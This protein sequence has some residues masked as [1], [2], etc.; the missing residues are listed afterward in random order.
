MSTRSQA[1]V[2]IFKPV[3]SLYTQVLNVI[4]KK[5]RDQYHFNILK[6]YNFLDVV[7]FLFNYPSS[8]SARQAS[9]RGDWLPQFRKTTSVVS[10]KVVGKSISIPPNNRYSGSFAVLPEAFSKVC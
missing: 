6:K 4:N 1:G 3:D 10:D 5:P 2:T 8:G 9:A 7:N